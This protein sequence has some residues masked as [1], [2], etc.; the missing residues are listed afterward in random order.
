MSALPKPRYTVEEYIELLKNS[1]ERFEYFDGEIV[2]MAAGK[3]SHS[4]IAANV[5]YDLKAALRERPCK[6]FGGDAAIKT[7]RAFPF[8]L[9]DVSVVCGE[10]VIEE[11][12]GIDMLINPLMIVEVLSPSTAAYDFKEKFV[13]YQAIASFEEYLLVSQERGH[14]THYVRQP[15]RLWLRADIIGLENSVH[16]TSL[17]VTLPLAEIY[18]GVSFPDPPAPAVTAER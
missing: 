13:A 2:S 15:D 11:M 8:R 14:V 12:Q 1:D 10:P 17:N 18:R 16:L 7:V 9:P 4:D 5:I 3:I 6:V